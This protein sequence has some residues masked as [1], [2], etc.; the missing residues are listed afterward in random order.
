M[1]KRN[2]NVV[3]WKLYI[4]AIAEVT[5]GNFDLS[6]LGT[7]KGTKIY[8]GYIEYKQKK[9]LEETDI[10]NEIKRSLAV[11]SN[12]IGA[13]DIKLKEYYC[14]NFETS[15]IAL[16]HIF[17]DLVSPYLYAILPSQLAYKLLNY[18]DEC[19]YDLFKCDKNDFFETVINPL[20]DNALKYKKVQEIAIKIEKV[21]KI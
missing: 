9:N 12:Y 14:E 18:N 2:R 20:H 16:Q 15:P 6:I 17:S 13:Q 7:L 5:Q 1:I 19:F 3:N 11:I 21:F 4:L 8:R 10:I